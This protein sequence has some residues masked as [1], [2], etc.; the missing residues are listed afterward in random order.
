MKKIVLTSCGIIDEQLIKEFKKLFDKDMEQLK[1]LYIPVAADVEEDT[2]WNW[3]EEE[4]NTILD[5][6]IKVEN[7]T[8]YRMDYEIDVSSYDCIYMLGCVLSFKHGRKRQ[9]CGQI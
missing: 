7:V 5:L 8:E 6:G 1:V 3:I 9:P 2:D 4:F